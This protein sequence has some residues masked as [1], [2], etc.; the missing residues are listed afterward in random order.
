MTTPN[1]LIVDD[2]EPVRLL[3]GRLLKRLGCWCAMAADAAQARSLLE[4]HEF[5]LALIDVNIP[6]VTGVELVRH[7]ASQYP[8]TAMLMV[9][10]VDDPLIADTSLELGAYGYLVKPFECNELL[11]NVSS[12]LRRRNVEIQNRKHRERLEELILVGSA[13]LHDS[14]ERLKHV[15]KQV[16]A[17]DEQT[18]FDIARISEFRAHDPGRH[19]ENVS[20]H[21]AMLTRRLGSDAE[22]CELFRL[23]SVLHDIGKI[24]IPEG[25]LLK[26]GRLTRFEFEMVKRHCTFGHLMLTGSTS[27]LLKLADSIAWTH[28]ER[29][30]GSGY[31]RGLAGDAIPLEGR[32]VA[33]ADV[34]DALTTSRAYKPAYPADKATD[35]MR[36]VR[37]QHFDP[38]LLDLFFSGLQEAN[39]IQA[40]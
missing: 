5:A 16:S 36:Q 32:I 11:I 15:G 40:A 2:E 27:E 33:I 23:A 18:I 29:Y 34:F 1:V 3:H 9:T 35:L 19:L 12:A 20:N 17:A 8:D 24:V 38:A 7:I 13:S 10:A 31:P 6:G 26:Q 22:T 37:G 39:D 4:E 21:C 14:I 30:D 25:T 28:H